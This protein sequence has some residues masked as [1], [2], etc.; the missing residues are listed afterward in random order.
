M[1]EQN[2]NYLQPEAYSTPDYLFLSSSAN[3]YSLTKKDN[4]KKEE[5]VKIHVMS[6]DEQNLEK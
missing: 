4:H 3:E 6:K 5:G 2:K 1:G